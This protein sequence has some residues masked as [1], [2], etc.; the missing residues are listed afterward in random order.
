MSAGTWQFP[1]HGPGGETIDL[2]RLLASHGF[3]EL[4]PMKLDQASTALTVTLAVFGGARTVRVGP[5]RKGHGRVEV[6]VRPA[7]ERQW[8]SIKATL[9]RVLRLDE[10]LSPF[11]TAV[12]DD[13]QLGW[14]AG[15]A[16][17]MIQSPTVFEDV[18][19]TI[20]TT[21]CAW[22]ATERM[23]GALVEHLGRRAHGSP[24]NGP[25]GRAFPTPAAM[26]GAGE[27]F[28]RDVARAGY[29]SA[30]L[31][32]LARDVAD[33]RVDLEQLTDRELTDQQVEERLLALPGVGPYAAAQVMMTIG[34]YHRL[35]LDSW[36]RPTYAKLRGGKIVGDA[37][38][39]RRFRRFGPYAGLAFWLFLTRDW[40]QEGDP[41]PPGN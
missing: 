12:A 10:D 36:T 32:Q 16:G 35:I 7:S 6:L 22:G 29:R 37:A 19:K 40:V 9:R 18:V 23:V 2:D 41:L 15:G 11:Y 4:P 20:C 31:I 14:I 30:Y 25:E 24:A 38:I 1:L 28:Y 39:E 13:P 26:A 3:V 5:G 17:R 21:N 33:G 8:A 34:R 27:R